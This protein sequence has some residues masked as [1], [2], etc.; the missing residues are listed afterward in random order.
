MAPALKSGRAD[1]RLQPVGADAE[2]P[3]AVGF[4]RRA[5]STRPG[6]RIPA[7][8]SRSPRPP[9]SPISTPPKQFVRKA[10]ERHCRVSL[11]DFGAGMSS[12][13]YLQALSRRSDQDRRLLHRAYRAKPLRSRDRLGHH[14]H[15]QKP[16]LLR[17]GRKDRA[18]GHAR[19]P[20]RHGRRLRPGF[21]AAPAGA[22][23]GDRGADWGPKARGASSYRLTGGKLAFRHSTSRANLSTVRI[24]WR[25]P[26]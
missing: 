21:S 23:G 17:G 10:R 24:P 13:E 16:R 7:S 12:F 22:A 1:A 2:R 4:R 3:A 9:P 19:H 6:R 18:A 20:P 11:D 8:A 15:R 14:R 25:L 26:G 5:S